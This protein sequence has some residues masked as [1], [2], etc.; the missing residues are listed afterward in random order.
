[1][2]W[3]ILMGPLALPATSRFLKGSSQSTHHRTVCRLSQRFIKHDSEGPE[4]KNKNVTPPFQDRSNK[5]RFYFMRY[6][7]THT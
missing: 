3:A 1:M 7:A 4:E 5:F 2:S 6:D